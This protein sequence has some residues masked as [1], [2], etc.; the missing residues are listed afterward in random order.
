M[1]SWTPRFS[2]R[3]LKTVICTCSWVPT[4]GV[5]FV[6][7]GDADVLDGWVTRVGIPGWVREGVLPGYYPAA[8]GGVLNQ[9]SGPR[10]PCR[11]WSGWVQGSGRTRY[12]DGGGDG[13]YHPSGPVGPTSGPSLYLPL[14]LPPYSQKRARFQVISYKVSQNDEVSPE[15]AEKACHSP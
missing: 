2:Y 15:F 4:A 9:R 7:A 11:G 5:P 12:G 3:V 14:R 10:K 13:R 6:L 1:C 8:R